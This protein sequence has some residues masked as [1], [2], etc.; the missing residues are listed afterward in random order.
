MKFLNRL[1]RRLG[2]ENY[3]IDPSLSNASV[4]IIMIQK[5]WALA[6][7]MWI[8]PWLGDS[9]GLIFIGKRCRISHKRLLYV[10]KTMTLGDQ[11]QINALSKEGVRIGNNFSL[12][13]NS[14]IECT[15]VI[16]E[17]GIGLMIGD[18][19]GIAQNCFIQVRGRVSIGNYVIFGPNVS[20][21]SENHRFE[22]TETPIV[23]QGESRKGV[24][25][26]DDVWVGAGSIIL[27]GVTIGKGS[28]IAAG[29]VVKDSIP[30][31]S[32]AAGV[33]AKIIRNRKN[34]TL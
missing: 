25:I 34:H 19:V 14:I 15:G 17:L 2:K 27:D 21:F 32:I 7:G 26:E 22:S 29:S 12:Q 11:V 23:L 16:R 6:R 10:G 3:S 31:Y 33:P 24:T 1:I 4:R 13:S 9:S 8:K 18:H 20:L 28:I 5:F 30:P